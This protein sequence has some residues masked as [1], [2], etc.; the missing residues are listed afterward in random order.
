[1]A[2]YTVGHGDRVARIEARLK[3]LGGLHVAGNAYHGI[4]IPDCVR[5]GKQA[6]D[7]VAAHS[8]GWAAR[9]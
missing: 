5:M 4:G 6:A 3:E 8:S 7:A 1:M 9:T 2:Q